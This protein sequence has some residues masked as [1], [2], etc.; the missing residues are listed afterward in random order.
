MSEASSIGDIGETGENTGL[1]GSH[2]QYRTGQVCN[3]CP[4]PIC[5]CALSDSENQKKSCPILECKPASCPQC[6]GTTF[7]PIS[8][9]LQR[10][11]QCRWLVRVDCETG[12]ASTAFNPWRKPASK[13]RVMRARQMMRILDDLEDK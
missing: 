2:T 13:R 12:K 11:S 3:T 5:V 7:T 8:P 1:S 6:A 4:S 10:C 9:T